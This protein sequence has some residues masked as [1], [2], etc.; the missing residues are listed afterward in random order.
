MTHSLL[1]KPGVKLHFGLNT[2]ALLEAIAQANDIVLHA[3]IYSNFADN[4]VGQLLLQRLQ[5]VSFKQLTL[6]KL[7]PTGSWRDE[8]A[9]ILRPEMPQREVERLYENSRHWCAELKR[10]FPE[11]VNLVSTQALPLQPILLIGDRLFVGHY[12]HSHT[13]SAQGLWIEFDVIALGLAPNS[14]IDWFYSGVTAE[15]DSPVAITL[16][17]YVEECRR[18]VGDLWYQSVIALDKGRH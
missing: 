5:S 11:T 9:T 10:Q 16:G 4:A 7:E 13:T 2:H 14:L 12:A 6:I 15:Q 17:R 1:S 8:F 18:A 3:A